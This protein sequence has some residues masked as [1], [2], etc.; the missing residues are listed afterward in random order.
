M[1]LL[2]AIGIHTWLILSFQH[3]G[4][5]LP[6]KRTGLVWL[7]TAAHILGGLVSISLGPVQGSWPLALGIL[8]A[9]AMVLNLFLRPIA[10]LI[11]VLSTC[12]LGLLGSV[13]AYTLG[14]ELAAPWAEVFSYWSF[15][16]MV[17]ALIRCAWR[18]VGKDIA[19]R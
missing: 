12:P 1:D 6:E 19:G 13:M 7:A 9:S 2:R 17:F 10:C 3:D 15:A 8:F 5:G 4:S 16:A 18:L 11:V 14:K